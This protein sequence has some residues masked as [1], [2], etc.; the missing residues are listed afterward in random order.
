MAGKIISELCDICKNYDVIAISE[1]SHH[2]LDSHAF[3]F[4]LF[5]KLK[6]KNITFEL[7][8]PFTTLLINAYLK[9]DVKLSLN[10]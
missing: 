7:L 10:I 9:G 2:S 6:I 3:Q 1:V 4:E 8:G 5:K